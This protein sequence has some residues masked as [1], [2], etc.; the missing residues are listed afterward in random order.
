MTRVGGG[1][2]AEKTTAEKRGPILIYSLYAAAN[3]E[4]FP[5]AKSRNAFSKKEIFNSCA[6]EL[7]FFCYSI[8]LEVITSKIDISINKY[9]DLLN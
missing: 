1:G 2:G 6:K 7:T 5:S 3:L 8:F 4:S 9:T